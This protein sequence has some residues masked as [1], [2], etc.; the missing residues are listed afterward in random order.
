MLSG[1]VRGFPEGPE[2]PEG[3]RRPT[4]EDRAKGRGAARPNDPASDTH[5]GGKR[6][7]ITKTILSKKIE[8]EDLV[9]VVQWIGGL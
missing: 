4:D 7:I 2:G 9:V 6:S 3:R 8:A 1:E 5:H